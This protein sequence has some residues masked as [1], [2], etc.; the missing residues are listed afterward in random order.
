[1]FF[2]ANH[3]QDALKEQGE[4]GKYI[5][6]SGIY[7][8]TINFI[9]VQVNDKN[10]RSLVFNVDYEGSS[11]T[12]YGLTL[13]NNDGSKNFKQDLFNKL[14]LIAGLESVADPISETHKV[15]KDQT[16]REFAVL[17]E[18]SGLEIQVRIQ[19]EYSLWQG[20]LSEKKEIRGFYRADGATAG[21]IE[22]GAGFGD[23]LAKDLEFA[24][25]VTYKDNL[26][27]D[28]VKTL[29]AA[30]AAG[31][32]VPTGAPAPVPKPDVNLFGN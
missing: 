26:T 22:A 17:E 30:K 11:N 5:S 9:S 28:K 16:E 21:E 20:A 1:M 32:A 8:V 13:D 4:G 23:K 31:R 6:K 2:T 10:A 27:A 25:A 29:K 15:G 12:L 19:E 24:E 18:F 14:V 7:P 3:N